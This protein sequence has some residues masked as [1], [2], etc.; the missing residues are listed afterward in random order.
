MTPPH[1]AARDVHLAAS[2]VRRMLE[3]SRARDGELAELRQDLVRSERNLLGE[4]RWKWVDR[5]CSVII[6]GAMLAGALHWGVISMS[7]D[8]YARDWP[9]VATFLQ[10]RLEW[11]EIDISVGNALVLFAGAAVSLLL[12]SFVTRRPSP[13]AASRAMLR[14][15]KKAEAES[16]SLQLAS[17]KPSDRYA[18]EG[19][20][21]DGYAA[22]G[23]SIENA[24][25]SLFYEPAS[26]S[27]SSSP[28]DVRQRAVGVPITYNNGS[29]DR[30]R[31][32]A[33]TRR[34]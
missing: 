34:S 16:R 21:A 26:S 32:G 3:F 1:I 25:Q 6:G 27:L 4:R 22:T 11:G 12:V 17:L 5:I 10:Y 29:R 20:S 23:I 13:R 8:A 7:G 24:L 19:I 30:F 14:R 9:V 15:L 28:P 2:N 18:G 33:R 31:A